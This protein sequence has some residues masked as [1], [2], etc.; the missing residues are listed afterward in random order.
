MTKLLS[1]NSILLHSGL[2]PTWN[3]CCLK[4]KSVEKIFGYIREQFYRFSRGCKPQFFRC[5]PLWKTVRLN[6][7][8]LQNA[9][10]IVIAVTEIFVFLAKCL[11]AHRNT[12]TQNCE[13]LQKFASLS[14]EANWR[15]FR[16]VGT[17][18]ARG[19]LSPSNFWLP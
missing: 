12:G 4:M 7:K 11:F 9:T 19:H 3:F 14:N 10:K 15:K 8:K 2:N 16:A 6:G 17:G 13:T 1:S 18:S 5:L